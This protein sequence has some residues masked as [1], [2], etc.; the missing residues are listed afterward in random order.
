[1]TVAEAASAEA[2][3]APVT[4]D[5]TRLTAVVKAYSQMTGS[6]KFIGPFFLKK[7]FISA[8]AFPINIR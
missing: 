7:R 1:M 8:P 4:E 3:I 2:E 5:Y 6:T